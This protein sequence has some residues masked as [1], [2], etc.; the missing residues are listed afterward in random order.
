METWLQ[1]V[2]FGVVFGVIFALTWTFVRR[3]SG[4]RE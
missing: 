3:K 1:F 4:Y 2:I